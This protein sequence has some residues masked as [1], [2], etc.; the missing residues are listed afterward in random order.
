MDKVV[1]HEKLCFDD[2]KESFED[3]IESMNKVKGRKNKNKLVSRLIDINENIEHLKKQIDN[4]LL[5]INTCYDI[6]PSEKEEERIEENKRFKKMWSMLGPAITVASL[7]TTA[8]IEEE[9]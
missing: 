4:L 5:E 9:N 7:L 1:K 6:T 3:L 2:L 8:P